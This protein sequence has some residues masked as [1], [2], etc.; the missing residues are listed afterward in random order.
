MAKLPKL[1]VLASFLVPIPLF[2][3]HAQTPATAPTNGSVAVAPSAPN[4]QAPDEMTRKITELVLAGKYA[5]AQKLT[6]GLLIA[7]PDDQRLIKAKALINSR[8]APGGSTSAAPGNAQ[9]NQPAEDPNA[10][11][12]N[13]MDK[14]DYNA[15]IALARQAQQTTDLDEQKKML[16]QFMDQSAPFLQKHPDQ[17]LLWQLRAASAISLNE[18][19]LGYEAGQKLLGAGAADS[20]DPALQ[21]LLG[22]LKNK[23]W[24][25]KQIAEKQ[26]EIITTVMDT[27]MGRITC[28]L[29]DKQ[30]PITVANFIGLAVGKKDWVDPVT[31]HKMHGEPMFNGTTFHRVVPGFIIQGGDPTGTGTGG[32]GYVFNDEFQS[33]LNFDIPGRLAMANSGPNTNGSQFFITAAAARSLDQHDTIFGQCDEASVAVVQS[34]A[35]V[36]TN[37]VDG[38]PK[39]PVVLNKVTIVRKAKAS[40][41]SQ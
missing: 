10:E 31:H 38:K 4:G 13:G 5:E 34:I 36:Q 1:F 15:L 30:A 3:L 14:V 40:A 24:L 33:S 12:L 35:L 39:T 16:Q 6:E 32:P 20:N 11:Q 19:M 9:P 41:P 17:M 23:G 7:Y 8:L 27:S 18:P 22:Q 25:D 37:S 29:F 28:M 21:Q 26:A 2:H